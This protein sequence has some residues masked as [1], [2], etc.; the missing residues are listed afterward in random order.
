MGRVHRAMSPCPHPWRTHRAS[1]SPHPRTRCPSSC[2]SL[3][4][5]PPRSPPACLARL[6]PRARAPTC[7]TPLHP[8]GDL[9]LSP[10]R[11]AQPSGTPQEASGLLSRGLP[12]LT[13]DCDPFLGVEK[14][15]CGHSGSQAGVGGGERRAGSGGPQGQREES[16][17]ERKPARKRENPGEKRE[18]TW[19]RDSPAGPMLHCH[20]EDLGG[21]LE[22]E[23]TRLSGEEAD[24]GAG[25]EV[26]SL[27][28]RVLGHPWRETQRQRAAKAWRPE[29]QLGPRPSSA[30]AAG[31]LFWRQTKRRP[32]SLPFP[33]LQAPPSQGTF[34]PCVCRQR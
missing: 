34:H 2:L 12:T 9:H 11:G 1:A 28:L 19:L 26:T 27:N 16:C 5:S 22:T 21:G 18:E 17:K 31:S 25:R 10:S 30:R 29:A 33:G 14:A 4:W 23:S 6:P 3:P 15:F 24:P 8:Q 7:P 13:M 32:A 20:G